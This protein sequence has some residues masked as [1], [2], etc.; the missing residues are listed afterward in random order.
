MTWRLATGL[1]PPSRSA[2]PNVRAR[3]VDPDSIQIAEGR[4]QET[5]SKTVTLPE[6]TRSR[7]GRRCRLRLGARPA[8]RCGI[9]DFAS[10]SC[11][12]NAYY[13]EQHI[14]NFPAT[15]AVIAQR[16]AREAI[17]N[18]KPRYTF[19]RAARCYAARYA[20]KSR[21]ITRR[22]PR[23]PSDPKTVA[24]RTPEQPLTSPS[25]PTR[26]DAARRGPAAPPPAAGTACRR[27]APPPARR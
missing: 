19:P 5:G 18:Y 25:A 10:W 17:R 9:L 3:S 2:R 27:S 7:E 26:P 4:R 16:N 23:S 24:I 12:S 14:P 1:V 6:R 15:P 20:A 21:S 8:T 11:Q 22:L 13:T